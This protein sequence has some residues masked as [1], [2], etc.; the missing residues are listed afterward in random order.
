MP[1]TQGAATTH[2]LPRAALLLLPAL[3]VAYGNAFDG[4]F[5]FDDFNVIVR[6][7][8]VQS[9]AA[10]WQAQPSIR[11]LLK[12]S[13]ALDHASGTGLAGFHAFNLAVHAGC[14]LLVAMLLSR[15]ARHIGDGRS[16][17]HGAFVATLMFALHPV[18]TEAVT[19]VSGRSTAMA[20]LFSLASMVLWLRGRDLRS[21]WLI[22]VASPLALAAALGCKEYPV[23]VPAALWLVARLSGS[24]GDLR[25]DTFMHCLTVVAALAAACAVARYR[26]LLAA[27][28]G[29]REMV[30]NLLTQ[31]RGLTYLAGQLLRVDR[32]NADPALATVSVPDAGSVALL[33]LWMLLPLVALAAWR[34]APLAAFSVLWFLVWLAPTQSVL[35]RF[36][37][38]NDRQLYVAMIGPVFAA[39][40]IAVR[41]CPRR[42][43]PTVLTVLMCSLVALTAQRNAVYRDEVAYWSD[44]ARKAPHNARA[45][46][47][48]GYALASQCRIGDAHAATE[49]ALALEPRNTQAAVR[50]ALMDD[51]DRP[52]PGCGARRN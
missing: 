42:L 41:C 13:Y 47:N 15:L 31:A 23:V 49:I 14:V 17:R 11:P 1:G 18:Q 20:A 4:G 48:L 25:R 46:A 35:P 30:P 50:L 51:R 28:L 44:V 39:S 16:A 19:Y 43:R 34:R 36:D 45:F 24:R 6:E 33:L 22:H 7:S 38:A 40:V 52:W 12:L 29:A 32:L 3:A 21:P 2:G 37:V 5:Q 26:V 27:S 8:T 9:M 10:W